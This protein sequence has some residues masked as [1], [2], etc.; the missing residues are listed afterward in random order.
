MEKEQQNGRTLSEDVVMRLT[1]NLDRNGGYYI[2]TDNF[3]TS[4]YLAGLLSQK[5]MTI[6]GTVRANS[7][8]LPK[9]I[10]TGNKEKFFSNFF[11]QFPKK[12]HASKLS[13]QTE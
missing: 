5:N 13:V 12:L 4:V 6:V 10:T 1:S 7:K 8:D 11:L 9:E 2:T 3:F